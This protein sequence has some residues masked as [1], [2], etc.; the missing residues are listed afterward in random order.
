[1]SR[2]LDQQMEKR[3][4]GGLYF[5]DRIWTL[6]VGDVRTL[7]MEEAHATKYF[8][9]P[10]V[11]D[12]HQRSSGLLPQP[13]I[14]GWKWEKERLTMDSKS[15]LSRSSSGCDAIWVI[16]DRLT[17]LSYFL[18]I[19]KEYKMELLARL[20]VYEAVAR[21]RVYVTSIPNS[22]GMYIEVLTRDVEVVRNAKIGKSSLIGPELV[23]ET[24]NKVVLIKE[25][26]KAT[27]DLQKSYADK[28]RKPLEFEVGDRV[29]LK[30]SPWKGVV[31]F[32]KKDEIK[33]DKTLCFI[34]E[35]AEIMDRKIKNLKRRKI[36][37]VKVRW[38]SKRG[39]EFTWEHED[40]MRIKYPQL[41]MD[42]V[43]EPT[44]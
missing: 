30:V 19:R 36:V 3:D 41:F 20:F 25:K 16:V 21:H 15:K 6:M 31:R 1:M 10:R 9:R 24:K 8:V 22:D 27:R 44:S 29:L 34:E 39:P 26:L 12:E 11:K 23:L 28:R 42:I 43:V 33:V 38:N 7:I 14:P 40:Q 5:L 37:I 18:A 35:P 4:G 2:G 32:G 13:E 17:K